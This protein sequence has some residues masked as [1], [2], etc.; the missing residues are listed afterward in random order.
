VDRYQYL[1]LLGGCLVV[2]LP[3]EFVLGVRVWRRPLRLLAA[4]APGAVLFSLWDVGAIADR[5]WSFNRRYVTGWRLPGRLPVEEV[6][7]FVV[8]PVCALLTFGVVSRALGR[9]RR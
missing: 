1:L 8:I 6:A 7:F 4:V 9:W 2:T 3:L 5:W